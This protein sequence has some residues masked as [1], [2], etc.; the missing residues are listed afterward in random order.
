VR[1]AA[2]EALDHAGAAPDTL[3]GGLRDPE[4]CVRELAGDLLWGRGPT[5]VPTL[6]AALKDPLP[7]AREAAAW[8]LRRG[9]DGAVAPLTAARDD[10]E[11]AVQDA[12]QQALEYLARAKARASAPPA[13]VL[14][15]PEVP[16]T[17]AEIAEAEAG[18]ALL[19]DSAT[20]GHEAFALRTLGGDPAPALLTALASAAAERRGAAAAA[21]LALGGLGERATPALSK[22]LTDTEPA[23]RRDAAHALGSAERPA[24]FVAALEARLADD[25]PGVRAAALHALARSDL[26]REDLLLRLLEDADLVVRW[27]A[28]RARPKV[29]PSSSE[30]RPPSESAL[31]S[32]V[33]RVRRD[34]ARALGYMGPWASS[35][36]PLLADSVV[37]VADAAEE[38]LGTGD[39]SAALPVARLLAEGHEG[40]LERAPAARPR[41]RCSWRHWRTGT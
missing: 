11:P 26:A 21:L 28:R 7:E 13:E 41:S 15:Q 17:P 18:F 37:A 1:F 38:A 24:R 10:A 35:L 16:P 6:V 19:E 8:A 34:T 31:R 27:T 2:L 29:P 9:G 36:A 32:P 40:V 33:W 30:L 3:A 12:A 20:L 4:P 14:P 25:D 22:A 5:A 39:P 23:V